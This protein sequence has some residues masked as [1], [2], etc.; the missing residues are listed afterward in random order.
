MHELCRILNVERRP[1]R[2]HFVQRRA[3]SIKIGASVDA[4]VHPASLFG[5]NIPQRA[6]NILR[7]AAGSVLT[8]VR[9]GNPEI[10]ELRGERA[11][12]N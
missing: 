7:S 1:L 3:Q 11:R 5:R 4:S 10:R 8:H 6:L 2:E 9:R 12:I